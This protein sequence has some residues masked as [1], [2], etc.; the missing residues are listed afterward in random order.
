MLTEEHK[1]RVFEEKVLRNIFRPESNRVWGT[2]ADCRVW[3]CIGCILHQIL[4]SRIHYRGEDG[5]AYGTLGVELCLVGLVVKPGVGD[6]LEDLDID[7][8]IIL[9]LILK[10]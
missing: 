1:L 7:G 4:I 8:M 9:K 5:G 6:Y 3:S 2:A 10:K